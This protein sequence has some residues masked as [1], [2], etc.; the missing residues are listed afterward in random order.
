MAQISLT[1]AAIV[2]G[3]FF[4]LAARRR[5]ALNPADGGARLSRNVA[6]LLQVLLVL[7]TLVAASLLLNAVRVGLLGY[8][9]MMVLGNGSNASAL[10]WYQDRFTDQVAPA[11]VV[12]APVLAYRLLMLLWALWLAASLLKWVKWAWECFSAGGYWRQREVIT[13]A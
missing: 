5:L 12:S 8:P 2:G 9:D 6:N 3:W 1:G 4:M 10:H 11:W 7:W 13:A